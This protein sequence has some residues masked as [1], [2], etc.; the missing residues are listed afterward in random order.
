M[1]DVGPHAWLAARPLQVQG[2]LRKMGDAE[3]KPV[4]P[5]VGFLAAL[6]QV[7]VHEREIVER[8]RDDQHPFGERMLRREDVGEAE[9]ENVAALEIVRQPD[10]A[11][12]NEDRIGPGG[13]PNARACRR[14]R[15]PVRI[16]PA[17]T[18]EASALAVG[19][20]VRVRRSGR[21]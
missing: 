13:E 19:Y 10:D 6:L 18:G 8:R 16:R 11:H 7:V 15:R 14:R 21:A 5:L 1:I 20:R 3:S 4:E 12:T 9:A 17:A 2:R